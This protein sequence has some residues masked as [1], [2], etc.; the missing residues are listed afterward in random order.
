MHNLTY[1]PNKKYQNVIKD[2][3]DYCHNNN[4]I[5]YNTTYIKN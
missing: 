4:C 3:R 5:L 2:N 1:L